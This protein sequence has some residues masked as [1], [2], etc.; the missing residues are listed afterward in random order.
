MAQPAK[1][2]VGRETWCASARA[3]QLESIL[4]AASSYPA[5]FRDARR[6]PASTA[7]VLYSDAAK[8]SS[9]DVGLGGYF[10]REGVVGPVAAG[11]LHFD[12]SIPVLEMPAAQLP[13]RVPV[14]AWELGRVLNGLGL[15]S[16]DILQRDSA[17]STL[18]QVLTSSQLYATDEFRSAAP[19]LSVSHCY[20]EGNPP[21]DA[22]SRGHVQTPLTT[23]RRLAFD[24]AALACLPRQRPSSSRSSRRLSAGERGLWPVFVESDG[25]WGAPPPPPRGRPPPRGSPR[26]R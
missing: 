2:P 12:V 13:H 6:A 18:M 16:A 23:V 4:G 11:L 1:R 5:V 17:K 24:L 15:T 3:A 9:A 19:F 21:A 20:G 10:H 14:G 22:A 7:F 26:P 25:P 8:E